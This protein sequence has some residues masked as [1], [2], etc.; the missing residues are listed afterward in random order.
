MAFIGEIEEH[1]SRLAPDYANIHIY[2]RGTPRYIDAVMRGTTR[3]ALK[4]GNFLPNFRSNNLTLLAESSSLQASSIVVENTPTELSVFDLI[5]IGEAKELAEVSDFDADGTIHLENELRAAHVAGEEVLLYATRVQVIGSVASAGTT[6]VGY[7]TTVDQ[8][9]MADGDYF[10]LNDGIFPAVT[11]WFNVTG[12]YTPGGGYDATNIEVDV[13]GDTTA[14]DVADSVREAVD[15]TYATGSITS[16]ATASLSDGDNFTL[17]DGTSTV[18]FYFD[19]TGT[20]LPTDGY[21]DTKVRIYLSG[22][23][24]D[25][26]VADYIRTL[27]DA[28]SLNVETDAAGTALITFTATVVGTQA[29]V[30]ITE[31][32]SVGTLNPTGMSGGNGTADFFITADDPGTA[33]ITFS[34]S[35]TGPDGNVT[36][37]ESLAS[38]TLNPVGMAGGTDGTVVQIR[39]N[40]RV[41]TGD[42]LVIP[43][44]PDFLQSSIEYEIL[45]AD[46]LGTSGT[47]DFPYNTEVTLDK[48]VARDLVTDE[49]I[50]IRA[51]PTY[52]SEIVTF[53]QENLGPFLLDYVSGRMEDADD[54]PN[55][56]LNVQTFDAH[57]NALSSTQ[58]ELVPKNHPILNITVPSNVLTLWDLFRGEVQFANNK[59]RAICDSDG[60]FVLSTELIPNFEPGQEWKIRL[61]SSNT[62][63][64]RV[65]FEPNDY[66]DV[67]LSP[68]VPT[69]LIVGTLPTEET[70]TRIEIVVISTGSA[71][72]DFSDWTP[73]GP[74]VGNAVTL[75]EAEKIQ[76]SVLAHSGDPYLWQAGSM[77]VKPL[78][79][80]LDS[81]QLRYDEHRYNRGRVYL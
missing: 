36:I 80:N 25:I 12:G 77:I 37:V 59:A 75:P 31:A 20:Y 69:T 14:V 5:K 53:P 8:A 79:M 26:E 68:S 70:A 32:L 10:V 17:S 58:L 63:R 35:R 74:Y 73:E 27:V 61:I 72:V 24:T 55:E 71:Y 66:R 13:S 23:T 18:T 6:P 28:A 65:K 21:D 56:Y 64:V 9:F 76:Y 51:Y 50:Y 11:F 62:A 30:A 2:P 1:V 39:S 22:L 29:N 42:M 33:L 60:Y 38:G 52:L 7:I 57:D 46:Y 67:W 81:L 19:K 54:D 16:L 34:N 47:G 44:L 3:Y 43:T 78:F 41:F 40:F 45:D 4:F 15:G 49:Y 48:S